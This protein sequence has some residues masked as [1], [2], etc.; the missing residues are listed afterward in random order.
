MVSKLLII[1]IHTR[2]IFPNC[3]P[4]N[5]SPKQE[6]PQSL[7]TNFHGFQNLTGKSFFGDHNITLHSLGYR[8]RIMR[9]QCSKLLTMQ[10]VFQASSYFLDT[11]WSLLSPKKWS[12]NHDPEKQR[13][14]KIENCNFETI[15]NF[16]VLGSKITTDARYLE[17]ICTRTV[18]RFY[19]SLE[20]LFRSKCPTAGSKIRRYKSVLIHSSFLLTRRFS[21]ISR[22]W[23]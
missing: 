21:A 3:F 5:I 12:R 7:F 14:K 18:T 15:K 9:H 17:N 11:K 19:F 13:E 4:T 22:V 10:T 2:F 1:H 6:P 20:K 16:A 8:R 23:E